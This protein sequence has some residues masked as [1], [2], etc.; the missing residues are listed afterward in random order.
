MYVKDISLLQ[1]L[2]STNFR[3]AQWLVDYC[4]PKDKMAVSALLGI[5]R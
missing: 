2:F 4:I 1:T 3:Q 5:G